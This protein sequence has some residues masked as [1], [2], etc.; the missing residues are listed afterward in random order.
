MAHRST[1]PRGDAVPVCTETVEG[2]YCGKRHLTH[3]GTEA[4][5]GHVVFDRASYVKGQHRQRLPEPRPCRRF[6]TPGTPVCKNHG[7]RAAQVRDAGARRIAEARVEAAARKLI[8][9]VA[10]RTVIDN[11]LKE[12]L[13]LASEANAFRESLRIISNGLEGRIRGHGTTET[14]RAEVTMYRQALKDTTDILGLIA[15]LDIEKILA[16]VTLVQAE[17]A[18]AAFRAG[19]DAAGLTEEQRRSVMTN[20]GR[21][22]RAVAG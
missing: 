15:R 1:L 21:H 4:C 10:D 6:A 9:E 19:C 14:V 8:P 3:D 12:L 20:A 11:P 13:A 2:H 22:L 7:G 17:Q 5:A 18:L 16:R